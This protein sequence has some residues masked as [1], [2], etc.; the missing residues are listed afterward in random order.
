MS[1]EKYLIPKRAVNI[2]KV[3][4][5]QFIEISIFLKTNQKL[6]PLAKYVLNVK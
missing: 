5:L 6:L 4:V 3:R 1:K 2:K